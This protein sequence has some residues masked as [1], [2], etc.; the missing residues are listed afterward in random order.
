MIDAKLDVTLSNM[1]YQRM[2]SNAAGCYLYHRREGMGTVVVSVLWAINGNELSL[3]LY[4][5]ILNQIRS[6]FMGQSGQV[7]LLS[8][9]FTAFPE[10]AKHLLAGKS[11]DYQWLVDL[12]GYRLMIYENQGSAF[13][14]LKHTLEQLLYE[15]QDRILQQMG[16][17]QM[18]E[19]SFT[20]GGTAGRASDP[21]RPEQAP[22]N[23]APEN[24]Y[25]RNVQNTQQPFR[26]SQLFTLINCSIVAV[27]IIMYLITHFTQLFGGPNSMLAGGA[28]SWYDVYE[29]HQYY[30][31]LT[32]MFMHANIS[33]IFNNMLVL[34]F[35]GDNLER[36]A[37]RWKYLFLY[38]GSGILAGITSISY[39]MWKDGFQY[40]DTT[41]YSIGAS[42]AIFGVVGAMLFIVMVNK[43]RLENISTR[44]MILF[45]IFS[46]YGGVANTQ[47]DMAAH[48]GGFLAG[49]LLAAIVYRRPKKELTTDQSLG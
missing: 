2:N 23:T 34:L 32:A 3:E 6:N 42:G 7:Q 48:I 36:A 8:L 17:E 26:I 19:R 10:N 16:P 31:I 45:A 30:R 44:Q 46:I 29:K 28:L 4:D 20:T 14:D 33:H 49:F 37:G 1:G 18:G 39:N 11:T 35:L 5:N 12:T 22:W 43:G 13:A 40:S 41:V 25:R 24:Q 9:I 15:E 27:N 47:I 38:F 21:L